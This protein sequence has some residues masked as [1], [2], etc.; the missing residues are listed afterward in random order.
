MKV[1][2]ASLALLTVGFPRAGA[3]GDRRAPSAAV[4][5]AA[6]ERAREAAI[7]HTALPAAATLAPATPS[8]LGHVRDIQ[9][10]SRDPLTAQPGAE[11]DTEVEPDIA[12]DPRHHNRLLAVVQQ[13]RFRTGGAQAIGYANSV[14]GGHRWDRATLPGLTSAQGGRFARASDPSVAF[15]P[16]GSAYAAALAFDVSGCQSAVAVWRSDDGGRS[17]GDLVLADRTCN[18]AD[19]KPWI[20]VDTSSESH[21]HGRIYL[22]WT[23]YAGTRGAIALRYSDDQAATWSP[24]EVVSTP[25]ADTIDFG[26]LPLIEPSGAL[27]V[28][29]QS[30]SL[31]V[32]TSQVLVQASTDGGTT[33]ADPV[34]VSDFMGSD[35]PDLRSGANIAGSV[36]P[37]TGA[38][39]VAWQDGRFR[40]DGLNDIVV[41]RST[42]GGVNWSSPRRVNRRGPD[43]LVDHFTPAIAAL[44]EVVLACYRTRRLSPNPSAFVAMVCSSSP[45]GGR[46][47]GADRLIG[48]PTDLTYSA[49]L[50]GGLRFLGDYMGL[51]VTRT[52]FHPAWCHAYRPRRSHAPHHQTTWT[53]T[54][55]S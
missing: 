34:A 25:P 15:A 11:A 5:I 53:A 23:R 41:A 20:G 35:E 33:F 47:W 19:D 54:V 1:A 28:G 22:V 21:Y 39:Y 42:D 32:G 14:N 4:R 6:M 7:G 43:V 9:E 50:L 30:V 13:G 16:H 46:S 55:R 45:N 38:L 36:D 17:F 24:L 52:S 27:I 48:H 2:S 10:I 40:T 3:A 18:A 8:T 37:R 44:D 51:A 12:A 26:A 31:D 29:Y 49:T